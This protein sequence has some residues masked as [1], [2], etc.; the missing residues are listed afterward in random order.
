MYLE[1]MIYGQRYRLEGVMRPQCMQAGRFNGTY[2]VFDRETFI[3]SLEAEET[4]PFGTP[5]E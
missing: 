4:L 5:H 1:G 2:E 3:R